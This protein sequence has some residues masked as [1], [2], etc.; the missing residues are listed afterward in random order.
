MRE[1]KQLERSGYLDSRSSTH[2]SIELNSNADAY[3]PAARAPERPSQRVNRTECLEGCGGVVRRG[4]RHDKLRCHLERW[5]RSE[6]EP[7]GGNRSRT[8][9]Q[10]KSSLL[11]S[12]RNK[13]LRLLL[14]WDQGHLGLLRQEV[15][16]ITWADDLSAV[17]E[18]SHDRRTGLPL[19]HDL[20]EGLSLGDLRIPLRGTIH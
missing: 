4:S 13:Y 19:W 3:L 6:R 11:H 12:N 7:T 20:D 18:C 10:R 9:S 15:L 17:W 1:I 8:V 2:S 14:Y 16:A 5:W